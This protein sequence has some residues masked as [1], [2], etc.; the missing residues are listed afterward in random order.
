MRLSFI[1]KIALAIFWVGLSCIQT[2]AQVNYFSVLSQGQWFKLG[3]TQTGIYKINADFLNKAGFATNQLNPKNIR[4]YGNGGGMLPQLLG[5]HN[6]FELL[7]NQI[8]VAGQ[9][10][11]KFDNQD[12]ILFY[13]EG[14]DSWKLNPENKLFEHQK[15]IYA[16]TNYYFLTVTEEGGLRTS[17][18]E[19][20][21]ETGTPLNTFLDYHFH[22]LDETNI[23]SSGREW[24]GEVFNFLNERSFTFPITGI[25]PNSD[26]FL[27]SS[28]MARDTRQTSFEIRTAGTL[29]GEQEISAVTDGT[30]DFKGRNR[31]DL[32]KFNASA[33]SDA[34]NLVISLK[35]DQNGGNGTGYLNY[36]RLN[37]WRQLRLYDHQT[38]F[39]NPE[40]LNHDLVTYQ[41]SQ[42]TADMIIWDITNPLYPA[43]QPFTWANGVASFS[44]EPSSMV[45][46]FIAFRTDD[47]DAPIPAGKIDNQGLRTMEVP[48]LVIV[49]PKLLLSEAQRLAEFRQNHD[50]LKVAVVT[51]QQIYNEF[52]SGKQD[53]TAIRDFMKLLYDKNKEP[54]KYLLLFGDASYDYKDRINANTNL[55]SIYESRESL[56]PIFSY[57]SD[58]YY[59]FLENGEGTWEENSSGDHDLEIGI[60]RI[61]VKNLQE[62]RAVVDKLIAYD[63]DAASYGSWRNSV[64]FV[65]DDGD[66]NLHQR[67]ADQLAEQIEDKN[68]D[69][70]SQKVFLDAFEQI[71]TANGELSPD[72]EAQLNQA[73]ERGVL[74]VNFTGHGGEIGWTDE[75][76][77][78][79]PQIKNWQN[80]RNLPLFVTA[81]CEFG[82]FEDPRQ[83]S[84][85]E[86]VI[87]NP[88]GG[89]IGL[90][91]TTRPVFSSSNFALNT[92]FY[93]V[94]FKPINGEMPRLGDIMVLT[95]NKSL[96]GS[97]NRNFS[98]L[99]DPSM[100]LAY[101]QEEVVITQINGHSP[102][103][104]T[105]QALER[106]FLEGEI[107]NAEGL[108]QNDFQGTL[109]IS[110]FDKRKTVKTRGS[111]ASPL[112]FQNREIILFKGQ[113]S[114]QDGKFSLEFTVPKDIDY[115]IGSGKISLYAWNQAGNK[116]ANGALIQIKIGGTYED[117]PQDNTPPQISLFL[118]DDSF[119][120]S[121][122]INP[123]ALLI[124]KLS[125]ESGINISQAGIGHEITAYLDDDYENVFILNDY[126]LANKDTYTSGTVLFPLK[127]L[128]PGNHRLTLKAWD[129][130]NNSTTQSIDFV[131]A[132]DAFL[133]IENVS[134]YPNPVR[135][136]SKFI[137]SHNK[138]GKA[139]QIQVDIINSQGKIV[140]SLLANSTFSE[141]NIT[142]EW[143]ATDQKGQRLQNGLYVYRLSVIS[144]EDK[145]Q[146][147]IIRKLILIN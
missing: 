14:P 129:I 30:Y 147:Q 25:V 35:Y 138:T 18:Q 37:F 139:L 41:I 50:G 13:A 84:G 7:Q 27:N 121:D 24:Y 59:G 112:S 104:D 15:N 81:T 87:L 72:V 20:I 44:S 76:I 136:Q 31:Q 56:H 125:D 95:K 146:Q 124:A 86:E 107:Q 38:R 54:L 115:T 48:N 39:R 111:D 145:A 9:E 91:T 140:R 98:L 109:E 64:C 100:R 85:A 92:A 55:V 42:A 66:G 21:S 49:T 106:V 53:V 46:E 144:P 33:L 90:I 134:V 16:D 17:N 93:E 58:D 12:F 79:I 4:I 118:E 127:N 120:P 26:I 65:A 80:P 22:E 19:I 105:L 43:I 110:V 52:S 113:A 40:S 60:G 77:L 61:P 11:G 8:F 130:Y 69:F 96:S 71:P 97:V 89:G 88:R 128:S 3:V 114:I 63:A 23:I 137:F 57:S 126:Y 143:N 123:E 119:Q 103:D 101:P 116:D 73:V 117:A 108:L 122:E 74:I 94:V 29:I 32:F 6:S 102:Q 51:T 141:P 83:V 1:R 36:L 10:D 2:S 78:D 62:A 34:N 28:V 47:L 68:I 131:V 82:R 45:R 70:N 75:R 133:I 67:D 99:G 5:T 142:I 135:D 132:E